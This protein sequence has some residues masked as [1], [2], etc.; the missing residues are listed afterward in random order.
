MI[1]HKK[2]SPSKFKTKLGIALCKLH[3]SLCSSFD[4]LDIVIDELC[5]YKEALEKG[6]K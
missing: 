4:E 3:N 6:K 1:S 5:K 2:L